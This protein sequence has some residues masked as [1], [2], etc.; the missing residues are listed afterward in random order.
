ME[1]KALK[2]PFSVLKIE[3]AWK[4]CTFFPVSMKNG[5]KKK[6]AENL[7]LEMEPKN[8]CKTTGR[9]VLSFGPNK[10]KAVDAH[11]VKPKKHGK[12]MA[13]WDHPVTNVFCEQVGFCYSFCLNRRQLMRKFLHSL[14][15]SLRLRLLGPSRVRLTGSNISFVLI[16]LKNFDA[17]RVQLPASPRSPRFCDWWRSARRC[18]GRD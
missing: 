5:V 15:S 7:G 17:Q 11:L 18:A 8:T 14:K 6:P 1:K 3:E 9:L 2:N 12:V 4:R 13:P 10:K 16:G